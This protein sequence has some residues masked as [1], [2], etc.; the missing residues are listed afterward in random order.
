M[1]SAIKASLI[2]TV[3]ASDEMSD[4][5]I[6]K[7]TARWKQIELF[8]SDHDCIVNKVWAYRPVE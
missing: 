3:D 7:I 6:D 8:L 1:L 2:E 4:D 5:V